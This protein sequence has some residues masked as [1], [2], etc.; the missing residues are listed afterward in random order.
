VEELP[1]VETAVARIKERQTAG[2]LSAVET[3]ACLALA[4]AVGVDLGAPPPAETKVRKGTITRASKQ[5]FDDRPEGVFLVTL[6]LD[7]GEEVRARV[8]ADREAIVACMYRAAGV[9]TD[10]DASEL[11]GKAV[12][13]ELG[14]WTGNDGITRPVVRKWLS[15]PKQATQPAAKP[16]A[17]QAAAPAPRPVP[18]TTREPM[19]RA[20]EMAAK[21]TNAWDDD[22]PF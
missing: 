19:P 12:T 21:A 2:Q 17:T 20:A 16:A 6:E 13:I 7:D 15:A 8:A 3:R 14:D 22:I 5:V 10:A 1:A 9:A 4:A 18:P 11:E